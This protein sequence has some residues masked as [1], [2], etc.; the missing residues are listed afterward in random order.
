MLQLFKRLGGSGV[1]KAIE[2]QLVTAKCMSL[3]VG[4]KSGKVFVRRL[5]S[6][7]VE[8]DGKSC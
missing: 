1:W 4:M 6:G 8:R 7:E 2:E 3:Q 5:L